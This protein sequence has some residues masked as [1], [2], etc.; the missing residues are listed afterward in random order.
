NFTDAEYLQ[1]LDM[2]TRNIVH[3]TGHGDQVNAI[4]FS[5]DGQTL[6]SGGKDKN[7]KLWDVTLGKEIETF[8]GDD[9]KSLQEITSLAFS[10]DGKILASS[11][12]DGT[13]KFWR[14]Q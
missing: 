10:P 3:V 4:T 7:I 9:G 5:P 6:V 13:I 1:I 8:S 14:C 11:S 2:K 12:K